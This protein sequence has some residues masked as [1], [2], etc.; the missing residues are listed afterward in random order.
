METSLLPVADCKIF[1]AWRLWPLR[2][3]G[4]GG[5][6]SC[7]TCCDTRP[8]FLRSHAKNRPIACS[9]TISKEYQ[10]IFLPDSLEGI[11][12]YCNFTIT[13][14]LYIV[15]SSLILQNY[16]KKL[17]IAD[18]ASLFLVDTKSSELYARI[19][20]TG[21]V[22]EHIPQKEIRCLTIKNNR[23]REREKE[24]ERERERDRQTDRQTD[25][26]GVHFYCNLL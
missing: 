1:F 21:R 23:E 5:S 25:R 15:H 22:E 20:D 26:N 9:F 17:V 10:G 16:A 8:R 13:N 6:V 12:N 4:G 3:G 7:H 24:R 18:R 2:R 14:R 19:F 11:A